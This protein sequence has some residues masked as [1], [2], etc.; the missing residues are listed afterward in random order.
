MTMVMMKSQGDDNVKTDDEDDEESVALL[1]QPFLTKEEE[2]SRTINESD[3]RLCKDD[4]D[5]LAFERF[6]FVRWLI[7]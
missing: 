4:D 1:F 7:V 2:F 5:D 6:F 3:S